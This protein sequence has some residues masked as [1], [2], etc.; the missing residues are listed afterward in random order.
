MVQSM[1]P[2]FYYLNINQFILNDFPHLMANTVHTAYPFHLIFS[3]EFFCN[4]LLLSYLFHKLRKH[5]FCLLID[6]SQMAIQ[7]PAE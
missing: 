6:V 3:L 7:L 2:G 5:I 1:P 4:T